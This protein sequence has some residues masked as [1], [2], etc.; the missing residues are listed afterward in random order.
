MT[1]Y[2][3]KR[4]IYMVGVF[5]L[6]SLILFF[7]YS[8][9][10]G[11]QARVIA[12]PYKASSPEMYQE[13]YLK[14]R[15]DLGLDDPKPVQYLRWITRMC[16]GEFGYSTYYRQNVIDLIVA[17][18][19]NTVFINLFAIALCLGITIPLGIACAVKRGSLFDQFVRVVTVVG[20]SIPVF[21]IGLVFIY[22]FAVRLQWFPISG[23]GTPNF[24]GNVWETLLDKLKYIG[25][26]LIVM[27]F[28]HLG[29]MTKYVRSAMI[30]TLSSDYVRTARAKG[31]SEKVVI[32]SHAFR[33]ALLP[34]IT[35]II[36]WFLSLF[37]GSL[38][39]ENMFSLNGMGKIY[40]TCL[41]NQDYQAVMALQMFYVVIAL[42]GNLIIDL[43][44]MLVDPRVKL[45]D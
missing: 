15:K 32:Y 29:G 38:I 37:S 33:N 11:D 34:I 8:L 21:I 43:S 39:I 41:K 19:E 5:F 7:I 9:V 31:L 4:L 44:Y 24:E 30:E 27:T 45:N 18:M 17:P 10:P 36:G 20:Y 6:I 13:I 40:Y 12:E 3:L 2:I 1:K 35:L 22:I 28:S 16:T 42:V 23:F 25:L 26:P 14:A